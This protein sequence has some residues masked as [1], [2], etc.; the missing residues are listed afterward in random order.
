MA[1]ESG[2]LDAIAFDRY[3]ISNPDLPERL[4]VDIALTLY[5]LTA[6]YGGGAK[7]YTDYPFDID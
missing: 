2:T 6:F 7:G 4:C 1:I 3:F 5:D